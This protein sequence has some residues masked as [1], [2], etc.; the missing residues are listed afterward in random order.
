MAHLPP[1]LS[2]RAFEAAARTG[3]FTLAAQELCVTTGAISRQVRLLEAHLGVPLFSRHHRKVLLTPAGV[4]Y[5]ATVQ[6]VFNE[7]LNAGAGLARLDVGLEIEVDCLPTLSM[8][9][10]TP[11]VSQFLQR[12]P[13]VH[14]NLSTSVGPI[15]AHSR[16]GL[17]IR[18][19]PRH[20]SGLDATPF[21][22]ERSAVLCS[23][24]FARKHRLS[25]PDRLLDAPTIYVRAREDL[26]PTWTK[27]HRLAIPAAARRLT[28]DHTFAA[29]Q[30]AEDGLG[31]VVVPLLFARKHL[32]TGRLLMPFPGMLAKTGQYYVLVAAEG[33]PPAVAA[34]R[35]W[36]LEQG[37]Q[38]EI[39]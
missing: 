20:F 12:H 19:D 31:S 37:G 33:A 32:A 3:S 39:R 18:R 7:L 10:L 35:D 25:S 38:E 21:M 30:A 14:V 5:S 23:P 16:P 34:F 4:R 22:V 13:D 27:Q 8:Y 9:W 6:H 28:L 11:R 17:S 15:A 29:L 24:E 2:L 36:L 26:W 1:L